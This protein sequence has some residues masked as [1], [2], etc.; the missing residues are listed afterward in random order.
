MFYMLTIPFFQESRK[1]S[2]EAKRRERSP[3]IR[4]CVY[5][6]VPLVITVLSA[7][8]SIALHEDRLGSDNAD[9]PFSVLLNDRQIAFIH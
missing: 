1:L 2:L 8:K 4:F 7:E 5:W 3:T 9:T 6:C